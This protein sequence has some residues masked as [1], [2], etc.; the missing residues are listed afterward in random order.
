MRGKASG[1]KPHIIVSAL[2]LPRV[3]LVSRADMMVQFNDKAQCSCRN[4]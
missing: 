2:G 1:V 4:A 3:M